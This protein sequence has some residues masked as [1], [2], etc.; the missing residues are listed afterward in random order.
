MKKKDSKGLGMMIPRK[1]RMGGTTFYLRQ[2]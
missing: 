1:I 2:G